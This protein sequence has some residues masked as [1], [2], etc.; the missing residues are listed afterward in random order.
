MGSKENTPK[1]TNSRNS[2]KRRRL[3]RRKFPTQKSANGLSTSTSNKAKIRELKFYIYD[4][5][6][7]NT[8]ESYGKIVDA[9]IQKIQRTFE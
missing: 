5:A 2:N 8:L 9:I 6:Q 3:N 4:S 1:Q 7:R